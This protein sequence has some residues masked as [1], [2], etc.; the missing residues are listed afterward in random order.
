MRTS[1]LFEAKTSD[2]SKFMVCSHGRG[3]RANF[4]RTTFMD[5]PWPLNKSTNCRLVSY[6]NNT[7]APLYWIGLAVYFTTYRDVLAI[8]CKL[9]ERMSSDLDKRNS[10]ENY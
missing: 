4:L 1:T 2:F 8:I 5:D 7:V 9:W 3:E 10:L 6:K